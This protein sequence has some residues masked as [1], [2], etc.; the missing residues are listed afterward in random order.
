V[1]A[2]VA[3]VDIR[4]RGEQQRRHVGA[5]TA[6]DH[7]V[8]GRLAAVVPGVDIRPHGEQHL[9]NLRISSRGREMQRRRPVRPHRPGERRVGLEQLG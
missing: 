2:R 7:G 4:P 8:Q 1:D 9:H 5:R 3:R 6:I